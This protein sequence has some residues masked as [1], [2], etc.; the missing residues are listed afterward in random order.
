MAP[1]AK[2]IALTTPNILRDK[3]CFRREGMNEAN[4]M[5]GKRGTRKNYFK[6]R[7]MKYI[8]IYTK[9]KIACFD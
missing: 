8:Y 5:A 7:K 1:H 2:V 3:L 4:T 6:N 9:K